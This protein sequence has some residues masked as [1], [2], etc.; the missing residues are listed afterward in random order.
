LNLS[1][2][3]LVALGGI[4]GYVKK[5]SVPSIAAGAVI[6]ASLIASGLLAD[7]QPQRAF[8]LGTASSG[9]LTAAM[10]HR[11]IK[12]RKIMPSGIVSAIGAGALA[13]NAW[14]LNEW[15]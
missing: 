12:T 5:G 8:A 2:G 7:S 13:F 3:A 14:K 10:L 4:V 9:V 15:M 11:F 6:G 1:V